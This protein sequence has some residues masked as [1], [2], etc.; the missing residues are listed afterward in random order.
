MAVV[1]PAMAVASVATE[2][3]IKT[4][5]MEME[6]ETETETETIVATAASATAALADL[7]ETIMVEPGPV[8]LAASL[9]APHNENKFEPKFPWRGAHRGDDRDRGVYGA[10]G[11][12]GVFDEG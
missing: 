7:A 11:G 8:V 6:M 10:G 2:M 3:G 9:E 4:G 12:A 5:K 1:V